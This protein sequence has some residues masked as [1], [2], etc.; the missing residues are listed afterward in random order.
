MASVSPLYVDR[1][2]RKH[3]H[4]CEYE[5]TTEHF[6]ELERWREF[7]AAPIATNY[8]GKQTL[9]DIQEQVVSSLMAPA[10]KCSSFGSTAG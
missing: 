5:Y 8:K 9:N 2:M 10:T 1:I 6:R 7:V 4:M 3:K